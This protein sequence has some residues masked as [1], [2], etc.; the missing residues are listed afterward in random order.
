GGNA[1]EVRAASARAAGV[2]RGK[3]AVPELIEALRTKDTAVLYE[4]VVA[5]GKIR[6][7]SAGAKMTIMVR[8][9]EPKVQLAAIDTAGVLRDTEAIPDLIDVLQHTRNAQVRRAALGALGM[10]PDEESRPP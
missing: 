2:L 9:P 10:L 3:A 4:S 1:M 8:D 7:E 6:D 5:L